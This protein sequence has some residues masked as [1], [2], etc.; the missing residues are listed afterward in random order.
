[1]LFLRYEL[2][3]EKK[4]VSIVLFHGGKKKLDNDK[5]CFLKSKSAYWNDFR[6][7]M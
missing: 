3:K 1:M 4:K 7:I 5:K 2:I 6:R